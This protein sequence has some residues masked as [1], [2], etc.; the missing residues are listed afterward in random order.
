L[1][2]P[3]NQ[4]RCNDHRQMRR[5]RRYFKKVKQDDNRE[6]ELGALGYFLQQGKKRVKMIDALW[7]QIAL[8]RR[9]KAPVVVKQDQRLAGPKW[10]SVDVDRSRTWRFQVVVVM[11]PWQGRLRE[12][13]AAKARQNLAHGLW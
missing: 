10:I 11:P 9:L 5:P 12:D 8:W 7:V 6:Q 13:G 4:R 1:V 3:I 2:V